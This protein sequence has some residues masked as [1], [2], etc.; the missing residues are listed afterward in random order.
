MPDSKLFFPDPSQADDDGLLGFGGNLEV[1]T[2]LQAY[3]KG[4]FPWYSHG[5]PIMWWS[6]EPRLVLFP[7][8]MKVSKSLLQTIKKNKFTIFADTHFS[9]VVRH[10]A[11]T[12][13]AGQDGTWI[14]EEMYLAYIQLHKEGYAHSIE[15]FYK[16]QLVGGLY[17]V[18]LGK[19]FF[20]ESMF[21]HVADASKVALW[22]LVQTLLKWNFNFIDAQVYTAHLVSLGAIEIPRNTFLK[23]LQ[24]ALEHET[25]KG[26]WAEAFTAL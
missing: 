14:T 3:S 8:K 7:E 15:V 10:C 12:K 11:G 23:M 20:G 1:D 4:I 5:E 17:G 26:S 19:A 22:S 21:H 24:S 13:R 18:S 25:K 2:L 16:N 9:E 6:P